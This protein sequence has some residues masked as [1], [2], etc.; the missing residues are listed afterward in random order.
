MALVVCHCHNSMVLSVFVHCNRTPWLCYCRENLCNKVHIWDQ[1]YQI[2][3]DQV[4]YSRKFVITY[5]DF[6]IKSD[7]GEIKFLEDKKQSQIIMPYRIKFQNL[8]SVS[9]YKD[10]DLSVK[11]MSSSNI[12]RASVV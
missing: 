8:F 12:P 11:D 10:I 1:K 6:M 4:R 5:F 3:I 2:K 7:L 9:F